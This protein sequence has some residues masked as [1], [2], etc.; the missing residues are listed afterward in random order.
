M[1]RT[2]N[3]Q[4]IE[5]I[6]TDPSILRIPR[7]SGSHSIVIAGGA[8]SFNGKAKV[9]RK[10][11]HHKERGFVKTVLRRARLMLDLD[12]VDIP[13]HE[14]TRRSLNWRTELA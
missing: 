9:R 1:S 3:T 11:L 7:N 8:N 13:P 6:E 4:P 2:D 14:A 10:Q 5:V 12:A